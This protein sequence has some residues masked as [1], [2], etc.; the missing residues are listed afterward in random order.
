MNTISKFQI[1]K[2]VEKL[3][4]DNLIIC[5]KIMFAEYRLTKK[6]MSDVCY[7]FVSHLFKDFHKK[8]KSEQVISL[9][10][11]HQSNKQ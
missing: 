1:G 8:V 6:I 3:S 9:P 5:C 11:P 4:T 2:K 10:N 7:Y